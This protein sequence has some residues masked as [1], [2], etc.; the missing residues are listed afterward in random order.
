MR[1]VISV[2]FVT[3][4]SQNGF[5]STVNSLAAYRKFVEEEISKDISLFGEKNEVR[6]ACEYSLTNGGK[7]L[8]PIIALMVSDALG[9][10]LNV[11]YS[12]VAVECIHTAS[13]VADDFPCMDN[14]DER[15]GKPS[16][17]RVYGET[18]ALLASYTLLSHAFKLVQTNALLLRQSERF[19]IDTCD[20]IARLVSECM[21]RCC[22]ISGITE[23]QFFDLFPPALDIEM[24][25]WVIH[26]K[27][28]KLFEVA[29]VF[30]W[31]FGGGNPNFLPQVK[32]AAYH[33]G[34]AFQTADDLADMTQDGKKIID[35]NIANLIGEEKATRFFYEEMALFEKCLKDL[36]LDS[37]SFKE[38]NQLIYKQVEK[39]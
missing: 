12:A 29:F 5:S 27:T 30:G 26:K 8:R 17:H 28:V 34:M 19:S 1:Y 3:L 25:K 31:L 14:D 15:R 11:T 24:A 7:R 37:D 38:M 16:L 4:V 20:M 18:V 33:F 2:I 23:G 13:L 36:S 39:I 6:D 22:G 21:I 10:G 9:K 35:I 32:E